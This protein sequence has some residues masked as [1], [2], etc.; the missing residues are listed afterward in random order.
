MKR[1]IHPPLGQSM[2]ATHTEE[3]DKH[4]HASTKTQMQKDTGMHTVSD[5]RRLLDVHGHPGMRV[6][7]TNFKN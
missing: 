6:E 3:L 1:D 5:T 4:T 7:G 2:W